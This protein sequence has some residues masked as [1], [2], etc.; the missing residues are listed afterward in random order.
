MGIISNIFNRKPA[1]KV[2]QPHPEGNRTSRRRNKAWLDKV[3]QRIARFKM[4]ERRK[5]L[6]KDIQDKVKRKQDRAHARALERKEKARKE[7]LG[8]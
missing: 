1:P 7:K 3:P 2:S 8:L 4:E 6:A 5:K